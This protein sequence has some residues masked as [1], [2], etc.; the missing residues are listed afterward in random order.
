MVC[1]LDRSI[2]GHPGAI[3]GSPIDL[4]YKCIVGTVETARVPEKQKMK[5]SQKDVK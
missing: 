3:L 1:T 2:T 5:I 4:Q